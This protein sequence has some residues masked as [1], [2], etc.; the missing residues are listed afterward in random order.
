MVYGDHEAYEIEFM[1]GEYA[2]ALATPS[3]QIYPP[4][5]EASASGS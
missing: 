1:G 3:P 5:R 2:V 4:D